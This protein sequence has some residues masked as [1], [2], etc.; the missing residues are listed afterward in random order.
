M[1][2]NKRN[3]ESPCSTYYNNNVLLDLHCT[4]SLRDNYIL[5]LFCDIMHYGCQWC[6]TTK[7]LK[8][9]IYY[10]YELPVV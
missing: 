6:H 3:H 1:V 2:R 7:L 9:N 5:L 8:G 10:L 4:T